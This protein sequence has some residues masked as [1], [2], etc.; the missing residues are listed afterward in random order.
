MDLV[1]GDAREVL[2][3]V[4]VED[5]AGLHD[6]TRFVGHISLGRSMDPTWLDLFSQAA[7][8]VGGADSPAPFSDST[9][10]LEG[11]LATLSEVNVERVEPDWIDA[12][13]LLPDGA[14]D[15][16]AGRWI[17][18][19]DAEECSVDP[20]EKPM[21]RELAGSI[22]DFCRRAEDAEDVLFLWSL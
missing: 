8:E 20:E 21:L 4:G 19:I 6:P 2:L 3:A 14:L 17:E 16:L 18:L 7:R 12:V 5:W 10:A 1:A 9:Y 13:A 22:V 11:R 15:R